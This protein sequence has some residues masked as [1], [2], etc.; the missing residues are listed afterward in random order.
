MEP[1]GFGGRGIPPSV[2]ENAIKYGSKTVGETGEIIHA[3]E[4]LEVVT[5]NAL[6]TVITVIKIGN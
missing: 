6:N 4:N 3:F 5:N 2:V 1:V